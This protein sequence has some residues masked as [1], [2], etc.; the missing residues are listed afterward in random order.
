MLLA[1]SKGKCNLS[2]GGGE[3]SYCIAL[4]SLF[5][6]V[7]FVTAHLDLG[8]YQVFSSIPKKVA[9]ILVPKYIGSNLLTFISQTSIHREQYVFGRGISLSTLYNS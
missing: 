6:L 7:S 8:A 4:C 5:K 3:C 9:S 2:K 1:L